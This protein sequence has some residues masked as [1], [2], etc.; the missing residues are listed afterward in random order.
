MDFNLLLASLGDVEIRGISLVYSSCSIIAQGPIMGG[1]LFVLLFD[2]IGFGE[3]KSVR[4]PNK[5]TIPFPF[6]VPSTRF[7]VFTFGGVKK[8][9]S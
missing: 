4:V 2:L 1:F 9:S 8:S 3:P 6:F 7:D 5:P